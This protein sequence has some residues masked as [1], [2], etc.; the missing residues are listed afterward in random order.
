DGDHM[1]AA[2]EVPR[3]NDSPQLHSMVTA[4]TGRRYLIFDPT[5]EKTVFGELEHQHQG[6][7]GI[8]MEGADTQVIQLPVLDPSLN[9]IRRIASFKLDA[10]GVL[11]GTVTEK[12]F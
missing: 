2:I 9:T 8:L 11:K 7:Y 12:R 5:S 1:I 10:D 4:S 6:S 3:G